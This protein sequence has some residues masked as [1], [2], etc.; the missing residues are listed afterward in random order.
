MNNS[1]A[2]TH[3]ILRREKGSLFYRETREMNGKV[4]N[5]F[6]HSVVSVMMIIN[7]ILLQIQNTIA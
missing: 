2:T 6:Q 5:T 3:T 4:S 1:L 7:R